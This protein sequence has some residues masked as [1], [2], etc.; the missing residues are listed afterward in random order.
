MECIVL[1]GGLGTRLR[2]VVNDLPKCMAPVSGKPFLY[3]ILKDL[4]S[5][6]IQH[7]ILALGYKCDVIINWLVETN[8]QF[9]VSYIIEKE[10]L[11]TGG[12][13]KLAL[14][15]TIGKNVLIMNGDS[16]FVFNLKQMLQMHESTN[17]AITIALKEMYQFSRYGNVTITQN[18]TIIA[19]DEKKFCEKGFINGGVYIIDTEKNIFIDCKQK[20]SFEKDVLQNICCTQL[21]NGFVSEGY[22]IDIGI[23]EDFAKANLEFSTLFL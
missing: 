8:W 18:N 13:I 22:F 21:L 16:F 6:N 15:K 4:E 7:V 9:K 5:K 2:T 10:P 11:G 12:A 17:A 20:F 3:Y 19:F 1:A 23:P 14:K